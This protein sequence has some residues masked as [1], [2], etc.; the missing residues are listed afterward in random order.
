MQL[1]LARSDR[2]VG[3][4]LTSD[5][6]RPPIR[7]APTATWRRFSAA[8][9]T[10]PSPTGDAARHRRLARCR[11]R[12]ASGISFNCRPAGSCCASS[13]HHPASVFWQCPRRPRDSRRSPVAGEGRFPGY[14]KIALK[15]SHAGLRPRRLHLQPRRSL[16]AGRRNCSVDPSGDHIDVQKSDQDDAGYAF[17]MCRV[18]EVIGG[19]LRNG[20][21]A[22][23]SW[24]FRPIRPKAKTCRKYGPF[25]ADDRLDAV[26]PK[27]L[28]GV[29]SVIL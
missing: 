13:P 26:A 19:L 20:C 5:S 25:A 12:S 17:Q 15:A 8:S 14:H 22:F 23:P 27:K 24:A 6:A 21:T 4:R 2:N 18:D 10:P 9:S 3:L 16:L 11:R 28:L 29:G 7:F 1:H